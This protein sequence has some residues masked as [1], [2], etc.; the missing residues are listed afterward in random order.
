MMS[1][2]MARCPEIVLLDQRAAGT[3]VVGPGDLV[4]EIDRLEHASVGRRWLIGE[5]TQLR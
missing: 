3:S 2:S 4:D 1:T 5:D